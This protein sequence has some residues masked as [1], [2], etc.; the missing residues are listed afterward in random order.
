MGSQRGIATRTRVGAAPGGAAP[1]PGSDDALDRAADHARRLLAADTVAVFELDAAGGL[2]RLRRVRGVD[3]DGAPASTFPVGHGLVGRA[4]QQRRP[5]AGAD[6][7]ERH[8]AVLAAPLTVD[9]AV[10]GGLALYRAAGRAFSDDDVASASVAAEHVALALDHARLRAEVER[11]ARTRDRQ[12]A[13]AAEV[14]RVTSAR[15]D[16]RQAVLDQIAESAARL[17]DAADVEIALLEGD[18]LRKVAGFGPLHAAAVE[19]DGADPEG[20]PRRVVREG[21]TIRV[22]DLEAVPASEL[23]APE[24]RRRGVRSLVAAPLR[25]DG[26]VVGAICLG[27]VEPRPFDDEA[28]ALL[29]AFAEHAAMAL[30]NAGMHERA[31]HRARDLAVLYRADEELHRSLHVD[32]VLQALVDVVAEVLGAD[33]VAVHVWDAEQG[34]LVTRAQHG[35]D[36]RTVAENPYAPGQGIAGTVYLR[37]EPIAVDDLPADPRVARAFVDREGI[38]SLLSVPILF[39]DDVFGVFGLNFVRR[40]HFTEDD[41]RL[42]A[43]VAQRAAIAIQNARLYGQAQHAAVLQE[44]QRLARELHDAVTQTLFAASL[45]AEVLP[46]MWADHRDDASDR[47]EELR[48]LTRGALAE[49][50]MLLLELRPAALTEASMRDLLRQLAAAFTGHARVPVALDVGADHRLPPDVQIAFYRIAQEALNNVAKHAEAGRVAV[51]FTAGTARA[52]L[53]VEDDGR[54]FEPASVPGGHFGLGIMAERAAAVGAL[55]EVESAPGRGTR[56]SVRWRRD[57]GS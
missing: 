14:L 32:T 21:G 53:L 15:P 11:L 4:V 57:E 3:P 35:F 33:K 5:L 13:A 49:M 17:C 51:R 7:V 40:R 55:A 29:E 8:G 48:E 28:I 36:P 43:A 6:G 52:E 38:Q 2:L 22:P 23:P 45:I 9:G 54:G 25:R 20:V 47:L 41:K 39:G 12:E 10:V 26:A 31:E 1:D 42:M 24:A 46:Q 27:R 34:L 30:R 19:P 37:R 44:R 56:L 50:R 16:D 18:R